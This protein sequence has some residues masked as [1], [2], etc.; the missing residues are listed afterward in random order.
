MNTSELV[1]II[2]TAI[3][4]QQSQAIVCQMKRLTC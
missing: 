2:P 4:N 1:K 3:G